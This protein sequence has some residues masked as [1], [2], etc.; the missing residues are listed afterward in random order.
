ME[1]IT[2]F[3]EPFFIPR[4]LFVNTAKTLMELVYTVEITGNEHVPKTGG[5]VLICNHT[6]SLDIPVIGFYM[7]RKIVM[8]GKNEVFSPQEALI[9][10]MNAKDSPFNAPGINLLKT[11]IENYLNILGD[12]YSHQIQKWG[13]MPIIRNYHGEDAK[14]AVAYYEE[15]ENYMVSL[16]KAGEIV[17]IFPEGTRTLSGVM[18]PF[19]ALAAKIA[20]RANVP[21]IPSGIS[22]AWNM[23]TPKAIVSGEARNTIIRYNIGVPILPEAFPKEAE[24]KAAKILTEE[25]EK[26]VYFLTTHPERRGQPRRFATKL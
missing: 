23:S 1:E 9:K 22:G 7:P 24:K 2:K 10:M 13:G 6:D 11:G 26:R 3:L 12:I 16:L 20:I 19:K 17:S 14:S 25:L 5:A 8:L 15:L 18:G 21:I 4:D